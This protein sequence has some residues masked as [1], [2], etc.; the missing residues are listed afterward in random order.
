MTSRFAR[1]HLHANA[2]AH[3]T[4]PR[5]SA[6]REIEILNMVD[7]PG[8]VDDMKSETVEYGVNPPLL[9]SVSLIPRSVL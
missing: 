6:Q 1:P 4:R 8:V 2:H 3:A 9:A 5:V 7:H